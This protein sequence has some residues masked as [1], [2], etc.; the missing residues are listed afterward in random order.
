MNHLN[1]L[2]NLFKS[3]YGEGKTSFSH[4]IILID[5]CS[6]D[7][8]VKYISEKYPDVIIHENKNIKGFAANNNKGFDLSRGEY[9]F[10]C[11]PDVIVL[12]GSIDALVNFHSRNPSIGVACPQLLNNDRTYQ[13]SIRRFH[14]MKTLLLR[15]MSRGSDT[16]DNPTVQKYLMKDFNRSKTQCIDWALGAAMLLQRNVYQQLN[17][18]D[19][20]FFLYVEDVDLCL[21]SWK[22]GYAVVYFPKAVF[23]HDHERASFKGINKL[24]WLHI[25]S[26]LYF[27]YKH[28]LFWR[29]VI[30]LEDRVVKLTE[31]NILNSANT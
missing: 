27:F 7:G 17:G 5:N 4:E 18:F 22:A 6:V 19:E 29:G 11:N 16:Y 10:L 12:P 20:N 3:L 13:L 8:S 28:K 21:R 1:K 2:N 30:Q 9:I 14:N 25:K 23:I 15:A 24:M 26:M 31:S